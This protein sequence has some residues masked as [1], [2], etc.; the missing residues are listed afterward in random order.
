MQMMPLRER[1]R[2]DDAGLYF[3]LAIYRVVRS[4]KD[5]NFGSRWLSEN[6]SVSVTTLRLPIRIWLKLMPL[7][8]DTGVLERGT[9]LIEQR[10]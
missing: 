6:E 2:L 3:R 4:S 5:A 10:E 8:L 7:Q 1:I 9:E